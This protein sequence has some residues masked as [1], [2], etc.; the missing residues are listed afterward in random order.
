VAAIDAWVERQDEERL[1]S[2]AIRRLIE[3][4]L[5]TQSAAADRSIQEAPA[6][7]IWEAR[8]ALERALAP[9]RRLARASSRE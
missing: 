9:L 6:T 4:G 2:E 8:I 3:H 1:R 5:A 7:T